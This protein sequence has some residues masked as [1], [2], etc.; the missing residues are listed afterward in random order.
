MCLTIVNILGILLFG[1]WT[2]YIKQVTPLS[3]PQKNATFWTKD[4]QLN[5]EYEKSIQ[6]E[7]SLLTVEVDTEIK[8]PS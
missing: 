8:F 2:L 3:I 4:V 5:K 6:S 1:V 7:V